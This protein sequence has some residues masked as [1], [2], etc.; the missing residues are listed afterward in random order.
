M[1]PLTHSFARRRSSILKGMYDDTSSSSEEEGDDEDEKEHDPLKQERK[2][3]AKKKKKLLAKYDRMISR[4][5]KKLENY[6]YSLAKAKLDKKLMVHDAAK[7]GAKGQ[8]SPIVKEALWNSRWGV[9]LRSNIPDADHNAGT[10]SSVVVGADG[11]HEVMIRRG[12]QQRV[13]K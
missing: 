2:L 8:D 4:S 3:L 11:M 12:E 10:K 5:E 13:A 1:L 9:G 7:K 6:H